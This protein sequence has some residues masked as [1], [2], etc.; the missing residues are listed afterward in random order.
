MFLCKL[1]IYDIPALTK[2]YWTLTYYNLYKNQVIIQKSRDVYILCKKEHK[3]DI[4]VNL[5]TED[6]INCPTILK[7]LFYIPIEYD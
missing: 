3:N 1:T 7:N 2:E 6:I 5:Y 4:N